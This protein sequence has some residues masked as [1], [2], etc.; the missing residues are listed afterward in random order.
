MPKKSKCH[1]ERRYSPSVASLSPISSCFLMI[2]S[3]S[4]SSISLSW[5]AVIAPCSRLARASLIA[6]ERKMLPTWSAR[7]GGL[8][9]AVMGRLLGPGGLVFQGFLR[10]GPLA[11][12]SAKRSRSQGGQRRGT[13]RAHLAVGTT[14]RPLAPRAGG[15]D[16]EE[17]FEHAAVGAQA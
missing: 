8:L 2:F 6:P 11:S 1:H 17:A 5:A 16:A 3:T 14:L 9:R 12:S 13:R 4:R 15:R 7:N 10:P